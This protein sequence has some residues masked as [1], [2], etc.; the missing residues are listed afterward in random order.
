MRSNTISACMGKTIKVQ[1]AY[2]AGFIIT[3]N[4][5]TTSATKDFGRSAVK[6][7]IEG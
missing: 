1:N 5:D 3:H 7:T 6:L 2:R 4:S